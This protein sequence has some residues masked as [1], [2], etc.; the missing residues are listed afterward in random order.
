ML[1]N[2]L[3]E[4]V[5]S[6]PGKKA[7]ELV[8]L[9]PRSLGTVRRTD[10]NS[11]LYSMQNEGLVRK[12]ES[13]CW[14]PIGDSVSGRRSSASNAPSAVRAESK[15]VIRGSITLTDEQRRLVSIAPT[16]HTLI[17]GEPGSGK[18][19]VL[20]HRAREFAANANAGSLLMLTY[21]AA[22]ASYT[23]RLLLAMGHDDDAII[24]TLHKWASDAHHEM[25][26]KRFAWV[27]SKQLTRIIDQALDGERTQSG[28]HR[29]LGLNASFWSEEIS[30]IYGQGI[31]SEEQYRNAART[32]RGTAVP[33]RGDDRAIAWSVFERVHQALKSAGFVHMDNAVGPLLRAIRDA[34]GQIMSGLQ[35]DH[36]FIDEVQD[37][38]PAWLMMM[39]RI[40]K[41]S[42]TLAGDL[43]QRI[44]RR[45]FAWKS[46]GINVVGRSYSLTG[47]FRT[48]REIMSVALGLLR[49]MELAKDTDWTPPS[50][51]SR[52]GPKVKI[53]LRNREE[54]LFE[55]AANRCAGILKDHPSSSIVVA[56]HFNRPL[57]SIAGHI[58]TRVPGT[59]KA[60]GNELGEMPPGV[61]VTTYFQLKGLEFDHVIL[62]GLVDRLIPQWWVSKRDESET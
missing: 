4:L 15:P 23:R 36:V 44:Y 25:T 24:T 32:G 55:E 57:D 61:L 17:R 53:V 21:N 60:K 39:A 29:L 6:S 41:T 33:V 22:L 45:N 31:G 42:L 16:G 47:S 27:D 20:A 43:G 7:S 14:W 37:F 18:T 28:D 56:H 34:N 12:D 2:T 9:L 50:L 13:H 10:V 5:S 51:P 58:A 38:H 54:E 59:R 26:G 35:Y 40:A 49:D 11:V 52:N 48:T 62:L 8:P 19:T 3:L 46:V 1:K 30:W